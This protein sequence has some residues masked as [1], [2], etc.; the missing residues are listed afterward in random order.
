MQFESGHIYHIYNQGNNRQKIFHDRENY[1]FFLR[2]IRTHILPFADILAW[3]LMPNH[4]H[5]MVYV[6]HTEV[7]EQLMS[8]FPGASRVINPGPTLSRTRISDPEIP[9]AIP[10]ATQ[11]RTRN[12]ISFNKSIGIMLASY[13]RAINK[14]FNWSGSLFRSETKAVCLTEVNGIS[15]GWI[16]TMGITQITVHDPDLDY[17]NVCFNYILNNPVKDKLVSKPEDWEFSSFSDSIG[18]RNGSLI[19]KSRIEEFGLRIL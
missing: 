7:D 12:L 14:Q 13:T 11:S 1:L 15:P 5:L 4:F 9:E 18:N 3:C 10:G 8:R 16:T 2:K 19:N 17:P 6:N